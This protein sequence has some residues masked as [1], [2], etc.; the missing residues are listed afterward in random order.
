M[1]LNSAIRVGSRVYLKL[2]IAGDPGVVHEIDRKGYAKVEWV[3]LPELGR[4]MRHHVDTL[5]VDESFVCSQLG[6]EFDS[7]AA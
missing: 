2:C 6:L 3:D 7:Q 4:W 1:E 5:V